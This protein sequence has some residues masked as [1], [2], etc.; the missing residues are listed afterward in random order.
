[1]RRALLLAALL[2]PAT[3]VAEDGRFA[4]PSHFVPR[5]GA[6]LYADICQG[7]HMPDA[8]G[9]AGAGRYPALAG[10]ARLDPPDYPVFIVLH[11]HGA[12]PGFARLLDDEQIAAIVTYVRTH[13]GNSFPLRVSPDV[14]KA[15]R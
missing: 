7:C 14:V 5:D 4:S 13:F 6:T 12:M 2:V 11:G 15:S 3:A 1:M 10:D 8:R 9:A